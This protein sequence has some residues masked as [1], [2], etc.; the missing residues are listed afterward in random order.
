MKADDW[1]A[2]AADQVTKE[3]IAE[4]MEHARQAEAAKAEVERI[5]AERGQQ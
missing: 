4:A 3:R 1:A 5:R 2:E